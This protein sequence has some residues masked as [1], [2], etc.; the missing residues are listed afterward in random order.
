MALLVT[1]G[2]VL[3]VTEENISQAADVV[4]PVPF[5]E[6]LPDN[7]I[8]CKVCEYR[9]T[10][11]VGATGVCRV[12]SNKEGRLIA[13]NYGVISQ[14][15]IERIEQRRFFHLFPGSRVFSIGGY[16]QNFPAIGN[17]DQYDIP[18]EK[19]ASRA[20]TVD[21]MIKFC[22]E[23]QCR[24]VVFAF[25]EP[26]MWYEYLQDA[27]QMVKANGM[28]S[29]IVTNGYF[30]KEVLDTIG[31]Y[32]GG[33]L[34][35]VNAFSEATFNVL[36]GQNYFQKVLETTTLALRKHKIHIEIATRL[37]PGVNDNDTELKTIATWIKQVLGQNVPWHLS[38]PVPDSRAVLE[39]AKAIGKEIGVNYIYLDSAEEL[40]SG[41]SGKSVSEYRTSDDTTDGGDTFCFKCHRLVIERSQIETISPGMDGGKCAYCTSDLN[42]HNTIWKL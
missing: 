5:F 1:K 26:S 21:K 3:T 38:S 8:R 9:C 40:A 29:G 34:I 13:N 27:V 19:A 18:S 35:E 11:E 24:G 33:M 32:V 23:R 36:T 25:N 20:L 7:K 16:G 28:Y 31:H 37:I 10:L 17:E 12:R 22:I 30:S 14:A 6:T 4:R 41:L 39:R 15:G 2:K 42:I